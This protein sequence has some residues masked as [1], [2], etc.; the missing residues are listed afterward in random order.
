MKKLVT[1]MV[2][3]VVIIIGILVAGPFYVIDEGEQA[4]IVQM[5]KLV[6]VVTDAG[7]HLKM[8]FIEEVV[9][10]PKRIMA[11][12]GEQKSMPTR[13]KQYIWVDITARWRI[14]DPKKFY[15]SISTVGAA[16]SK[17]A[18]II[19]SEVRTVIAENY[20]RETVRNSNIIMERSGTAD[21]LGIGVE[22]DPELITDSIQP[23]TTYEPIQ[24]GRRQ[25]AEEIL[26]RSRRM[27]PEYGIELIDVVAR[28]IRYSDELTQSV[29][30]RMIKERNQIAQAFRSEGEGKKAGWLG[31]MDNERRSV[32][33]AAYE[34]A[35]AIRGA[36]DAEASR[37]Y[38]EAYNQDRNFFDFWR[39]VESYRTTIPKFEKT[40]STD[41]DYFKY[42][43]S[44]QGR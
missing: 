39:A 24:K 17:L 43:Y 42:L 40:L 29:Y 12:N 44:P 20:L 36:A 31:R 7:F 25:L 8:P 2:V 38:A 22:L 11:W 28:Q 14:S 13:E 37:I 1:A 16:Y 33:S 10:Y 30:A 5:G 41:M 35:E 26:S 9:R 19:D 3:I 4:V 34:K 18:E 32:L 15:E 21:A 6:D 23:D 27:V